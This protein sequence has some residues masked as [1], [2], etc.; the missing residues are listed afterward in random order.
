MNHK[1]KTGLELAKNFF[2]TGALVETN[3][4]VEFEICRHLPKSENAVIVEFGMGHGNI[5]Q[6]ILNTISPTSKLYAFEV[7]Q[8]FCEHVKQTINDKRLTVINDGAENLRNH[9]PGNVD[10]VISSIPFSFISKEKRRIILNDSNE[11][12]VNE[13]YFSQVLLTKFK[14]KE[15]RKVF[16]E[17]QI[18]TL[19]GFPTYYIYHCR[20]I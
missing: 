17:C 10:G 13:A 1:F 14:S 7:N 8:D 2:V 16:V 18:S 20:K 5:T 11:L 3:S 4:E 6:E 12:L 15:F 19:K 9:I